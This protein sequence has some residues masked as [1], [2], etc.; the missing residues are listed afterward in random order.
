ML[1]KPVLVKPFTIRNFRA[2]EFRANLLK[3]LK[4]LPETPTTTTTTFSR[5]RKVFRVDAELKRLMRA[6]DDIYKPIK[7]KHDGYIDSVSENSNEQKMSTDYSYAFQKYQ[8]RFSFK[9]LDMTSGDGL[10]PRHK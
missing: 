5:T 9:D 6:A 10:M 8:N 7:L 2:A 4:A 1:R 3:K